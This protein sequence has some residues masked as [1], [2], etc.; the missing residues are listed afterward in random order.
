MAA[1][2]IRAGDQKPSR[3]PPPPRPPSLLWGDADLVTSSAS[4]WREVGETGAGQVPLFLLVAI[5][6]AYRLL[7]S[8]G[9]AVGDSS[10]TVGTPKAKTAPRKRQ[11]CF[12]S[13]PRYPSSEGSDAPRQACE[14]AGPLALGPQPTTGSMGTCK[15]AW[16]P[17]SCWKGLQTG[18]SLLALQREEPQHR[19]PQP[20]CSL[21]ATTTPAPHFWGTLH[22]PRAL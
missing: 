2:R 15:P 13:S 17:C 19:G 9:A 21:L 10:Q 5:T 20:P 22:F 18:S 14:E 1:D 11:G 4:F 3:E 16:P 12:T 6:Y 8:N 7:I